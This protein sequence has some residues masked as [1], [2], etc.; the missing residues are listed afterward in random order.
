MEAGDGTKGSNFVPGYSMS[1][2]GTIPHGSTILLFGKDAPPQDD[3][4]DYTIALNEGK[5]SAL[6]SFFWFIIF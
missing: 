1:R 5:R 6:I 4:P 2:R 3:K